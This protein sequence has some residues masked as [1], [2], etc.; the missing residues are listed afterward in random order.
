MTSLAR[1]EMVEDGVGLNVYVGVNVPRDEIV[2]LDRP[3]GGP[4]VQFVVEA[5]VH[6]YLV[7]GRHDVDKPEGAAPRDQLVPP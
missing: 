1:L 7:E 2:Q 6:R 5:E 3:Q 4:A